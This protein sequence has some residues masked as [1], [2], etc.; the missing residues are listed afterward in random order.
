MLK[1]PYQKRV[2]LLLHFGDSRGRGI[3]KGISEY[4]QPYEH[5]SFLTVPSNPERV[6]DQI[7]AEGC[8]GAIVDINSPQRADFCNEQQY[9]MVNICDSQY[10]PD[11]PT[12]KEDNLAVGRIAAEYMLEKG[13]HHFAFA[14]DF[15]QFQA[16]ENRRQGFVDTLHEAG[17]DCHIYQSPTENRLVWPSSTNA[18]SRWLVDLP[19]PCGL[20]AANDLVGQDIIEAAYRAPISIPNE[21]AVLGV[22]NDDIITQ[23]N[24]PQLSSVVLPLQKMGFEAAAMLKK[25]IEGE[26]VQHRQVVL[27]PIGIEKRLS[28][29]LMAIG[30]KDVAK[31]VRFIHENA[32]RPIQVS[33]IL[34]AVPISRRSLERRFQ[35]VLGRSPQQEIQ[36][37]HIELA[38]RLLAATNLPIPEIAVQSG[39]KSADRLAAVFRRSIGTTPTAYRKR[40]RAK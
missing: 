26:T 33:D 1:R 40:F 20:L 37:I 16:V 22:G 11:Y 3:S 8:D 13:L 10:A 27:Q 39:F 25:L 30:D 21:I 6:M 2:A 32:R 17:F 9:P 38:Q 24:S 7:V 12:V 18:L 36:R 29:D 19:K 4:A 23:M 31:A 28:S 34:D 35:A 14:Q 5:W 15:Y